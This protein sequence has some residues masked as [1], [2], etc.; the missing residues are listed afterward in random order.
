MTPYA[1]I[2]EVWV[3]SKPDVS[4]GLTDESFQQTK[5]YAGTNINFVLMD[6]ALEYDNTDSTNSYSVKLGWR[7]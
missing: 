7:F 2:G 6:L 1:G 3:D 4:T 5:Y